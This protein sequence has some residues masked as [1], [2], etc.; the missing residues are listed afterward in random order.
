MSDLQ[1]RQAVRRGQEQYN[2][3]TAPAPAP[4]PAPQQSWANKAGQFWQNTAGLRQGVGQA[5]KAFKSAGANDPQTV[6]QNATAHVQA[7]EQKLGLMPSRDA[8][9]DKRLEEIVRNWP[10]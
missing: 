2:E 9:L 6:I 1:Y 8:T 4:Q 7:M 3:T 5:V 10:V